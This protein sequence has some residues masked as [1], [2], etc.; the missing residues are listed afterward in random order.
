L[1]LLKRVAGVNLGNAVRILP[2]SGREWFAL[3]LIPFKVFVP[4]GYLMVVIQRETLG[5]RVDT[6]AV[7][8]FVLSGYIVTLL[9]L[10]FGGTIQHTIGPR[11]A[12]ISTCVFAV[13]VFVFG[14]LLLPYLAHT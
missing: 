3:L 6:G 8:S 11:R 1:H 7:T 5:Y 10:L 14:L 9:V 13:G 12:Y 4:A 2:T